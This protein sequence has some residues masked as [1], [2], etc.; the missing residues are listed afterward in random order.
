MLTGQA[1]TARPWT[2]IGSGRAGADG[3]ATFTYKATTDT[4]L[5]A[6]RPGCPSLSGAAVVDVK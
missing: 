3:R 6:R 2:V 4:I 1:D 5:Q